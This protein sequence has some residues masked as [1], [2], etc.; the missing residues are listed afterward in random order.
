[1]KNLLYKIALKYV[2]TQMSK[3][4]ILR[5]E[6]ISAVST[7]FFDQVVIFKLTNNR[8]PRREELAPICNMAARELV[9]SFIEKGDFT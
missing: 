7:S 1:M 3:S 4:N 5:Y 9:T 2:S 6:M 8:A